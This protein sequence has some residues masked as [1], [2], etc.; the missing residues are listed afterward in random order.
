M[1]VL[2]ACLQLASDA[3]ALVAMTEAEK[4]RLEQLLAETDE[5]DEVHVWMCT[6]SCMF[7]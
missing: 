5:P 2:F 4:N 3:G 1:F 6:C 7:V